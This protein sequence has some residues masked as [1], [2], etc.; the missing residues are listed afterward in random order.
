M[1]SISRKHQSSLSTDHF[2][3]DPSTNGGIVRG[4]EM[5]PTLGLEIMMMRQGRSLSHSLNLKRY[6]TVSFC[7][8][9]FL[10]NAVNYNLAGPGSFLGHGIKQGGLGSLSL[11]SRAL[12]RPHTR[13]RKPL[14]ARRRDSSF[15]SSES[16]F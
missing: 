1:R 12:T 8:Y 4:V 3:Q 16:K 6:M 14:S 15:S 7:A 5:R 9:N 13:K 11:S 10:L 2:G